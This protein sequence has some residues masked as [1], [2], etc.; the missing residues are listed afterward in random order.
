[1]YPIRYLLIF[2]TLWFSHLASASDPFSGGHDQNLFSSEPVFLPVEEAYGLS[3]IANGDETILHWSITDGYYLY[4]HQFKF[5]NANMDKVALEPEYSHTG[6]FI[7]DEFYEKDLE[8]Y[9]GEID[10]AFK[11]GWLG[12]SGSDR[13]YR[14]NTWHQI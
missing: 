3:T 4:R 1:M 11:D 10:L 5:Y 9:Y 14:E 7:Y 2:I 13:K 6:T 8:V 12:E